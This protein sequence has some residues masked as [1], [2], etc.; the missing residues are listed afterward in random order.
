MDR[1]PSPTKGVKQEEEK[2]VLGGGDESVGGG[3]SSAAE[4]KSRVL[5][6]VMRVGLLAKQLLLRQVLML[7]VYRL[8]GDL[9]GC[10]S[11]RNPNVIAPRYSPSLLLRP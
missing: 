5:V 11:Y 10:V 6:G 7:L 1:K 9:F 4:S 2:K 3:A 8:R